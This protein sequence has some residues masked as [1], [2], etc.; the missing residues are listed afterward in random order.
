V[1]PWGLWG[2]KR[3]GR[4][5]RLVRKA[6]ENEWSSVNANWYQVPAESRVII[7]SAGGG[8]WGDPLERDPQR[9]IDDIRDGMVSI[10]GAKSEYGVVAKVDGK[11]GLDAIQLDIEATTRLRQE[12]RKAHAAE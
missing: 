1:A 7:R 9:V 5:D 6:G 4:P 11:G 10:E 2:G 8:G 3:G 12:M